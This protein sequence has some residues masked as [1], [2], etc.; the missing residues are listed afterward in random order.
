MIG[1]EILLCV[2]YREF[3]EVS[4]DFRIPKKRWAWLW[5]GVNEWFI[6]LDALSHIDIEWEKF[7]GM[8]Y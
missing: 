2:F 6:F 7:V 1:D 5:K 8:C 3:L 4:G